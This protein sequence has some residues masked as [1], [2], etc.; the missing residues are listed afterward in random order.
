MILLFFLL[1]L[2]IVKYLW[3]NQSNLSLIGFYLI[4]FLIFYIAYPLS[5]IIRENYV[6]NF[7]DFLTIYIYLGFTLFFFLFLFSKIFKRN[8]IN[9]I[10]FRYLICK[11]H[12]VSFGQI[13]TVFGIA[14]LFIIFFFV[15]YSLIFRGDSGVVRDTSFY[16]TMCQTFI[17]P[18]L[19]FVEVL[20]IVKLYFSKVAGL[21]KILFRFILLFCFIYF[22]F[23]GR[24]ELILFLLLFILLLSVIKN[25]SL[26]R[27]KK[28]ISYAFYGF[29]IVLFSNFYQNIR[30]DIWYYSITGEFK[31]SKNI[32]DLFFDFEASNNNLDQR[33][34]T[35][36]LFNKVLPIAESSDNYCN[37]E[38]FLNALNT[39]TPSLL[40]ENKKVINVDD[41]IASNYSLNPIDY[42]TTIPMVAFFDFGYLSFIL[43]PLWFIFVFVVVLQILKLFR[44]RP[45]PFVFFFV[46]FLLDLYN[47][48]GAYERNLNLFRDYIM[49]S[50]L[51]IIIK[52]RRFKG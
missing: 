52:S 41:L 26:F 29:L 47:I 49:Y 22:L 35:F 40:I 31:I 46:M 13:I 2:L 14:A 50:V 6:V 37:G 17:I 25:T 45:L 19:F 3:L 27:A 11:A 33:T 12:Q 24:R 34:S 5:D 48:E 16:N 39:V 8:I 18:C 28:L 42:T 38:I 23:Y 1:T 44:S 30:M 51:F 36:Y 7:V 32:V 4:S 21:K 43:Y 20:C 10:S 9:L 15:K